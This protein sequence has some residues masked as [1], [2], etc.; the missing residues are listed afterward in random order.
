[1]KSEPLFYRK[2][3]VVLL[4]MTRCFIENDTLFCWKQAVIF[5]NR[6]VSFQRTIWSHNRQKRCPKS[7]YEKRGVELCENTCN[8][9]LSRASIRAYTQEFL[10]FC[11]HK[12][13]RCICKCLK[14][15]GIWLFFRLILIF[16]CF[17]PHKIDGRTGKNTLFA[18]SFFKKILLS[19]LIFHL[20]CDTC[21]SKKST[22]LLEGARY[23]YAREHS[24][25]SSH[26]AF[27]LRLG[28][29][30]VVLLFSG[31]FDSRE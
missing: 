8:L 10:C 12:C 24:A 31:A 17:Y 7:R 4:K 6:R 19:T 28:D 26:L 5:C 25:F 1:M 18:P 30:L 11:C 2:R 3:Y 20:G 15:S 21:D 16:Q 22:S 14:Y 13:H 23:A 29:S 27:H 9:L